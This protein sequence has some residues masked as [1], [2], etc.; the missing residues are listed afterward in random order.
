MTPPTIGVVIP[1]YQV[2]GWIEGCIRSVL[3]QDVP[4]GEIVVVDDGSTDATGD[5]A[6]R[7]EGVQVIQQDNAGPS[8]ARNR[9]AQEVTSEWILFLD[10]DDILLPG[11]MER[12]VEISLRSPS[13]SAINPAHESALADGTID[14]PPPRPPRSFRR[15]DLAAVIRRN[16]FIG[17]TLIKKSIAALFPYDVTLS[18]AED[19]LLYTTLL[20]EG[21]EIVRMGEPTIRRAEGRAGALTSDLLAIREGR[22][23]VFKTLWRDRR[24]T[25]VERAMLVYQ[26]VRVGFGIGVASRRPAAI[27]RTPRV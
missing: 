12:Y 20:L 16:P 24:L 4:A 26:R 13:A 5:I 9:G 19:L 1:A 3:E 14:R 15:R 17:N 18:Y 2:E 25:S 23:T 27:V 10:A 11:A 21:H 7:I 8:A 22:L 6:S